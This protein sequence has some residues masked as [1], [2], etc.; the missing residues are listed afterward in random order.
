MKARNFTILGLAIL[1]LVYVVYQLFSIRSSRTY[2]SEF[3][4]KAELVSLNET[5][6]MNRVYAVSANEILWHEMLGYARSKPHSLYGS[7]YVYFF[8]SNDVVPENLYPT[9][10][11][12]DPSFNNKCVAVYK[13]LPMGQEIFREYPLLGKQGIYV[14]K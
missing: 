7:T 9:E 2:A 3:E 10:P 8:Q 12:F 5:G 1:F 14:M 11:H 4:L 6:P 13:R